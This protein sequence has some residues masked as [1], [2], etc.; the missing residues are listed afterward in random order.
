MTPPPAKL[1]RIN[2]PSCKHSLKLDASHV[3][4]RVKCPKCGEVF[5]VTS[6]SP[7]VGDSSGEGDAIRSPINIDISTPSKKRLGKSKPPAIDVDGTR[8]DIITATVVSNSRLGRYIERCGIPSFIFQC[9]LASWTILFCGMIGCIFFAFALNATGKQ[10]LR[11][12]MND[13]YL[14]SAEST[15]F[16]RREHRQFEKKLHPLKNLGREHPILSLVCPLCGYLIIGT[17]LLIAAR[18]TLKG[19]RRRR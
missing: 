14:A 1:V 2:C 16:L 19:K 13:P 15:K 7:A 12:S 6:A 4:R 11:R 9:L 8:E 18:L 3:G 17:P 5:R 10:Q